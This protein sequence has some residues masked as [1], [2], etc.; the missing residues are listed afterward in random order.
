[1]GT[2]CYLVTPLHMGMG[3]L[4]RRNRDRL[5]RKF[6]VDITQFTSHHLT[7]GINDTPC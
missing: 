3:Y 5:C 2:R 7:Y 4:P 1:M 6:A